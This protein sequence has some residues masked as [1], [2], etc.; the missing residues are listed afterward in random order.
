MCSRIVLFLR[1]LVGGC[2]KEKTGFLVVT[3]KLEPIHVQYIGPAEVENIYLIRLRDTLDI[4]LFK[5][6][7]QL[8]QVS[9]PT[10]SRT[11]Y[12]TM[13]SRCIVF[14]AD[15]VTS[16]VSLTLQ[17][18]PNALIA[19][20]PFLHTFSEPGCALWRLA[21][22]ALAKAG[23]L[24]GHPVVNHCHFVL[25]QLPLI[26][27][28]GSVE[29]GRLCVCP[30]TSRALCPREQ[31]KLWAANTPYEYCILFI[32]DATLAH[33]SSEYH[34]LATVTAT[35]H[36]QQFCLPTAEAVRNFGQ[37]LFQATSIDDCPSL[38]V[39]NGWYV[40][41]CG[42]AACAVFQRAQALLT[43]L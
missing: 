22:S 14:V 17:Q 29:G 38:K 37:L 42:D 16:V 27:I 5:Y 24:Q 26:I 12:T 30:F 1:S 4:L 34:Y 3:Y 18:G 10:I 40:C 7:G 15:A 43:E 39:E 21:Q 36:Y 19:E 32:C 6:G 41:I 11:E 25:E 9:L 13:F 2:L 35:E 20:V 28:E 31:A 8:T 33:A 23:L